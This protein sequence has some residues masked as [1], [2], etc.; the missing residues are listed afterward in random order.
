MKESLWGVDADASLQ[1]V[2]E[3]P[4][5]PPLLS[6]VLTTSGS[7]QVRNETTVGTTLRASQLM[8][9]WVAALL[10][11]G[12]RV[13]V[14]GAGGT[15]DVGLEEVVRRQVKGD[16]VA[17]RIPRQADARWGEARV[18]RTPSDD[19]IVT[20]FAVV[21]ENHGVVE[22]A[23]V[24]LTGVSL[25]PVWITNAVGALLGH[26]LDPERI[27]DVA[28]VVG[29]EVQPRADY[30]GSETYR[31]AMASLLTRRALESCVAPLD[32]GGGR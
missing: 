9:E 31:R 23:R 29:E 27:R 2:L 10:A 4:D 20:A 24:T 26:A 6:S 12:A 30:L 16:L 32:A 11:L 7:W 3:D 19:P 22:E 15:E 1:A 8:P 28:S 13:S 14:E 5:C 17:L 21:R 25:D 18:S